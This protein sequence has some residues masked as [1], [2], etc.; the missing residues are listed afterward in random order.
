MGRTPV[1]WPPLSV[2]LLLWALPA[3]AATSEAV[4]GPAF[5]VN[6]IP[7]GYQVEPE[8]A[9]RPDGGFVAAWKE[10]RG[11]GGVSGRLFDAGGDPVTPQFSVQ[12]NT[13]GL[14]GVSVH[15]PLALAADGAGRFA[16][17]WD[18]AGNFLVARRFDAEGGAA[19]PRFVV[20][21]P[22]AEG[23]PAA[24]AAAVA[25]SGRLW[26]AWAQEVDVGNRV[27][28]QAFTPAGNPT[29]PRADLGST[30]GVFDTA[31]AVAAAPD[32]T[33]LIAW[34]ARAGD[35][36]VVRGRLFHPDG[37][38]GGT[39]ILAPRLSTS[40]EDLRLSAG[41]DGF[42]LV[43]REREVVLVQLLD[44][45]A[46]RVGVRREVGPESEP[47]HD[48]AVAFDGAGNVLVSWTR[49]G[50]APVEILG[51][52]FDGAGRPLTDA[53]VVSAD[54]RFPAESSAVAG[55]PAG[56][57]AVVWQAGYG[58][59]E[60]A[61]IVA[62]FVAPPSPGIVGLSTPAYHAL[63][64]EAGA[65]VSVLRTAGSAGSVSV[66]YRVLGE[67]AVAGQDFEAASG[68][69]SWA[70]GEAG[71]R[72]FTVSLFDDGLREGEE[73]ARVELFAP[74]GG[75][76]LGRAEAALVIGDDEGLARPGAAS[77]QLTAADVECDRNRLVGLAERIDGF[78]RG[79]NLAL[80]AA[81]DP[82]GVLYY[83]DYD[84][85]AGEGVDVVLSFSANAE[86]TPLL[87]NP[88][89][90]QLPS[91]SLTRNELAT[92]LIDRVVEPGEH[93]HPLFLQVV[94]DPTLDGGI[95]PELLR[96]DNAVEPDE[97][98]Q[99]GRS[100]DTKPGRGLLPLLQPCHD[101]LTAHDVHVLRVVARIFR[102][103]T[104]IGQ[105]FIRSVI[106]RGE[107]PG[108]YAIEAAAF[109]ATLE[110][111]L[112]V[113]FDADGSLLG[114]TLRLREPCPPLQVRGCSRLGDYLGVWLAPPP[115]PPGTIDFRYWLAAGEDTP[116]DRFEID[117]DWREL[118]AGT[119][120]RRPL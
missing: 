85:D 40:A 22:K 78:D 86:E 6:E 102:A 93:P 99:A 60:G 52:C 111:D 91:V 18:E 37:S 16:V 66:R 89:R 10:N 95:G 101:K 65:E 114:G 69:L 70:A 82:F 106:Y 54:P 24:P 77:R 110:L 117:F 45:D 20:A 31:V 76:V 41:P 84:L 38:Q 58:D 98:Y 56:G 13:T 51:R 83:R 119:T 104:G 97:H 28:V 118:L 94:L 29:G 75:A 30:T 48:P 107:E 5:L 116:V 36:R 120:W 32:G 73:R 15:Q 17:A 43:W 59:G 2:C 81:G 53:F 44:S 68:E 96:I 80:T 8:V 49:A 14:G 46:R 12:P 64:A 55:L 39:A 9:S 25:P 92:D 1:S 35:E 57:F 63:E 26:M 4:L 109:R 115:G 71:A 74:G 79:V 61:S 87:R 108:H 72:S 103:S 50:V 27:L 67:S 33:V 42:A 11:Q 34:S 62:R 23:R 21:A 112:H 100:T 3:P 19:G 113:T 105:D 47:A 7:D 90:P 88:A